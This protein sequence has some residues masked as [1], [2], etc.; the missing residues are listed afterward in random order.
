MAAV[1]TRVL[2]TAL[3]VLA[4]TGLE[5]QYRIF[6][7]AGAE[8]RSYAETCGS[9][10]LCHALVTCAYISCI[11]ARGRNRQ[12]AA[13][14]ATTARRPNFIKPAAGNP[15]VGLCEITSGRTSTCR[16]RGDRRS[17]DAGWRWPR[18]RFGR[19]GV[20]RSGIELWL[21]ARRPCTSGSS[22]PDRAA[23]GQCDLVGLADGQHDAPPE[24]VSSRK[25]QA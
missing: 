24:L 10:T 14:D 5:R 20:R 2:R 15:R 4:A 18:R 23:A 19:L 11:V 6:R 13:A 7:R 8:L 1:P 16:W 22:L 25:P 17:G 12:P 21:A 9:S 3:G